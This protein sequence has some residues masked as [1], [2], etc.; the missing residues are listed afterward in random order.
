MAVQLGERII[1]LTLIQLINIT[2][3]V[4][5]FKIGDFLHIFEKYDGNWWIGRK[6][7]HHLIISR[8]SMI[9]GFR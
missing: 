2:F 3:F 7:R 1:K 6:V 4:V 9:I 5:S 8:L